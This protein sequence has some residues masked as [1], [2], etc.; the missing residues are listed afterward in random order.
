MRWTRTLF[1]LLLA[2]GLAACAAKGPATALREGPR[3]LDLYRGTAAPDKAGGVEPAEPKPGASTEVRCRWRV[4]A[5]TCALPEVER[6]PS[7]GNEQTYARS[8]EN[9]LEFLFPRLPNPDIY[10]HVLPHLATEARVPVP[11]YTTA[12]PLYERVEYAL[13]GEMQRTNDGM[14]DGAPGG[15][16]GSG[17]PEAPGDPGTEPFPPNGSEVA[18]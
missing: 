16:V 4:F 9:E 17:R 6:E 5:W 7:T 10:I 11:G 12:V 15:E 3:M 14:P 8:S 13:P 18:R 2:A 1:I